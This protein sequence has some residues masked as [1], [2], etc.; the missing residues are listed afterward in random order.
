MN[1]FSTNSFKF[2]VFVLTLVMVGTIGFYVIGG[3]EWSLIDSLYMTVITLSSV[4]FEEVHP[5]DEFG[6]I[7]AMLLIIFGVSGLAFVISQFGTELLEFGQYRSRKMKKQIQKLKSHYI[8]CGYGRMG[9]VIARELSEKRIPFVVIDN[10]ETKIE[11][12]QEK[13]FNYIFGDATLEE[14]LI[15]AGIQSA[16]GVVV[17]LNTDQDNLFVTMSVRTMNTDAF[18]VARC[19]I[20]DTAAKLKRAGADKVVN[21]YVAG[22][23]KMSE[24]LLS[25]FLEDSVVIG[26]PQQNYVDLAIDELALSKINRYD[27]VAIRDSG[28]RDEFNLI[29]VGIIEENGTVSLNPKS[30]T[31][32]DQT[33]TIMLIGKKEDLEKLKNSISI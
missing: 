4:G 12:I 20:D 10:N 1:L 28:L 19:S 16:R 27:G 29:V 15:E 24:M 25:P 3:Q 11:K 31:V 23:H 2:I 18:L 26:T 17:T 30:G 22:G 32:L 21:P 8:I 13:G 33:Q 9:A 14:T 7:W 5:L 6:R